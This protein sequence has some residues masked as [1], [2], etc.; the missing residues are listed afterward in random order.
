MLLELKID[1]GCTYDC[2]HLSHFT[3]VFVPT[4]VC[5]KHICYC[6]I[7]KKKTPHE[8]LNEEEF[9]D[10]FYADIFEKGM[11]TS[12]GQ[13][14]PVFLPRKPSSLPDREAWQATVY[15]FSKSQTLQK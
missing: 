1:Q 11:A 10:E 3:Q 7:K 2:W 4:C 5:Y 12:I 14:A 15:K 9:F 6:K 13:K 8:I